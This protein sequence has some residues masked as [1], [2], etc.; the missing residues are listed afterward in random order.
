MITKD[1]ITEYLNYC[2]TI[3]RLS[4]HT[5]KAYKID[6][7]K[8]EEYNRQALDDVCSED[9]EIIKQYISYLNSIQQPKSVKRKLA[10]LKA[11]YSYLKCEGH[12]NYSPFDKLNIVVKQPFVLPKTVDIKLLTS[13]HSNL[14]GLTQVS[15]GASQTLAIRNLAIFELLLSTGL[16]VSEVSSL[17]H[18]DVN[19]LTKEIRVSGKGAKERII[20]IPHPKLIKSLEDYSL[21]RNP[22]ST[23][24]FINRYGQQFA[25][26]SIRDMLKQCASQCTLGAKVT[27]HMLRHTFA[28][29]LLDEDVDIRYIQHILGHSSITT[30]QIYTHVSQTKQQGILS[31]KNPLDRVVL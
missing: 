30:T 18:V 23:F 24:F 31:T 19:L 25:E 5:T 17:K 7:T 14:T 26:Y 27:P 15:V 4:P 2:S 11:F 8:F 1:Q 28:T 12:I 22:D 9:D 29:L 10:T 3:K 16:R 20:Q 13:M 6:L 21:H